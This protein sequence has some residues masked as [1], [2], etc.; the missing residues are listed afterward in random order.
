MKRTFFAAGLLAIGVTAAIAQS[1]AVEQRQ[2]LMKE[3]G[4]QSRT[5]GNMMRG[6][7]PY[8]AAQ[9]QAGLKVFAENSKKAAPLFNERGDPQKTGALPAVWESK[10]NFDSLSMKLSQ[11]AQTAMSTIKDEA[12]LKSEL[13]KVLQNCGTCH[14]TYRKS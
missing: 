3:M 6:Q 2:A 11:D 9:V 7:A 12:T 14:Q 13:P 4:A 10:A 8:D 1:N 5:L